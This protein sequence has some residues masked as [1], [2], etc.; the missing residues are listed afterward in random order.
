MSASPP[1][2]HR[3]IPRLVVSAL[4]GIAVGVVVGMLDDPFIGLGAGWTACAAIAS[5][6]TW[7]VV[8]RM[9]GA[10]TRAHASAEDGGRGASDVIWTVAVLASLGGV[11]MLL[12]AGS[13]QDPS[14]ILHAVLGVLM[15]VSSWFLIHVLYLL[16]YA[17]EYWS[18]AERRPKDD[19]PIDFPGDDAPDYFDF[20]YLA[21]C[22][23]MAYQVSD[24]DIRSKLL[25]KTV[26]Q[27]TLL[28]YLLGAVV[29]ACTVNL[30]VSIAGR[31][32]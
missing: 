8:G 18:E 12:V 3:A 11:G 19:E 25:R 30:V 16:R 26:F 7:L 10:E 14:S 5:L 1:L 13:Q 2:Q 15:V 32:G 20:A 28:S 27:H 17:R 6:W 29:V 23:G 31:G 9:D 24:T 22:L 21:F 4:L